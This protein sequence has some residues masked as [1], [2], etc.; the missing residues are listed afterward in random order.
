MQ[1]RGRD[2]RI[3]SAVQLRQAY[4]AAYG[5]RELAQ[6]LSYYTWVFSLLPLS[7]SERFLDVACGE[8]QL[9][10]IAREYGLLAYGVDISD[11]AIKSANSIL[12]NDDVFVADGERLPFSDESF[13]LIANLGS[14]EHYLHPDYGISEIARVL[15]RD[16]IACIVL[17]NSYSLLE[18]IW[19]VMKTGDVG[20]Q[21]QPVERYATRLEWVRLLSGN[22]L[23]VYKT[24]SYN[25]TV[26]HNRADWLWY[27][28]HPKKLLWL[29]ASLFVPHNLSG[30]F[31]F[32]CHRQPS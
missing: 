10:A 12:E 6:L 16:G 29:A 1:S 20:D 9:V 19:T 17:P 15:H 13:D 2:T 18:N 24:L 27:L 21:N 22:G 31:L 30:C 8:G 3:S 5:E 23:S 14:L 4:N 7:G 28:R 26:P 25:L 11:R 32:L